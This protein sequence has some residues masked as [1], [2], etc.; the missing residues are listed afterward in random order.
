MFAKQKILHVQQICVLHTS[1]MK[2]AH[3]INIDVC[4]VRWISFAFDVV[5]GEKSSTCELHSTDI[6]IIKSFFPFSQIVIEGTSA[7]GASGDF[8]IMVDDVSFTPSCTLDPT[9]SLPDHAS[10]TGGCIFKQ[11]A[12]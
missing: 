9:N 8:D 6:A 7:S 5:I 10:P 3:K 2:L 12:S 4:I 1:F 11:K